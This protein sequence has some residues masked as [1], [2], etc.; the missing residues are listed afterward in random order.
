MT[1]RLMLILPKELTVAQLSAALDRLVDNGDEMKAYVP[2]RRAPA[3]IK[4]VPGQVEVSENAV[5]LEVPRELLAA[6]AASKFL[7]TYRKR[8]AENRSNAVVGF[9]DRG[10][11]SASPNATRR[12]SI[13]DVLPH[14]RSLSVAQVQASRRRR[15]GKRK[16]R[17]LSKS[18][19][20]PPEEGTKLQSRGS[21]S[22][23]T[24]LPTS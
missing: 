12:K 3:L 5:L 20:K 17:V 13:M 10:G 21:G 7:E 11:A 18:R 6:K 8:Q 2:R 14:L 16:A 1:P 22:L 15:K 9:E 23:S 24:E 19:V 4:D